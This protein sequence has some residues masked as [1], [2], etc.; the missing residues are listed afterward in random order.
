MRL[1]TLVLAGLPI[2]LKYCLASF[3]AVSTASLPPVVKNTLFS[4][5]GARAASRSASSMAGGVAYDQ[6]GKYASLRV[7]S[8][9]AA[10]MSSRP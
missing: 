10:T 7:C 2:S 5:P 9:T 6:I 8:A 4:S 3:Q 1:I